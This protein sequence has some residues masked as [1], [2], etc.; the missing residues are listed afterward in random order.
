MIKASKMLY[1]ALRKNAST[2][3]GDPSYADSETFIRLTD[4]KK[5]IH[6]GFESCPHHDWGVDY[7]LGG[8]SKSYSMHENIQDWYLEVY[9]GFD[10][11]FYPNTNRSLL[12]YSWAVILPPTAPQQEILR[13]F[14]TCKRLRALPPTP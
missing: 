13:D 3:F 1:K 8:Y 7:S 10:V 9:W 2:M 11:M 5:G 12:D 6:V 4:D 14:Q